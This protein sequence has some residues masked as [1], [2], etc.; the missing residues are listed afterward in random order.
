MRELM[1][2]L[3]MRFDTTRELL[4]LG[5]ILARTIPVVLLAPFMGSQMVPAE[6]KMGLAVCLAIVVWP[7]TRESLTA[8]LPIEA[9]PVLFLMMKE[10]MIGFCI[11]FATSHIFAAMEV[12]GRLIDTARGAAMGEVMLPSTRQ[13]ATVAGN[14]YQQ[15]LLV[16]FVTLGGYRVFFNIYLDSFAKLPLNGGIDTTT[17]YGPL[18]AYACQATADILYTG[19][20]LAAPAVAAT[21]IVD[22]VFG[23]LN[24]V[25][26]QL[27]AYFLAM[28][29]KAMGALALMLLGLPAVI[30]RFDI[31][32][33]TAMVA[34][35][36]TIL[37]LQPR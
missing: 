15:L 7:M 4:I 9:L 35:E 2:T 31:Y 18:V 12:A 11:G 34:A 20:I 13:R 36:Q 23:I 37:L 30:Q 26:P 8:P 21:F 6:I 19:T 1:E 16:F 28:P 10:T 25:A 29:V 17:G 14:L 3:G 33:T 32:L 27:N 5:L 22:I 24:R